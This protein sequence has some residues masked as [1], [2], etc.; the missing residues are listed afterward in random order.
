LVDAA[1]ATPIAA[2]TT[3]A[4]KPP[5]A[6]AVAVA[7]IRAVGDIISTSA[8]RTSSELK[9]AIQ[10][11]GQQAGRRARGEGGSQGGGRAVSGQAGAGP[12]GSASFKAGVKA[13]RRAVMRRV[14]GGRRSVH[15]VVAL[16]KEAW[17]RV[18]GRVG[19]AA[20]P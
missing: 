1:P 15:V 11:R 2:V 19:A 9:D 4:T 17:W 6:A 5:T 10:A 7:K 13:L 16:A 12:Y 3:A 20:G 8:R 14:D 18:P